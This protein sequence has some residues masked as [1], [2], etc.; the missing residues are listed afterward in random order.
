M[1][2]PALV[3]IGHFVIAWTSVLFLPKKTFI[4]YSSSAIL[5]SLLVLILSILAVPLNLWRVKGGIKTKIFN[6]LSFIFGPFFIGTLWIFR[7]TYK[8]FSLYML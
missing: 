6:D 4:R 3:R 5:A 8:N 7:M 1:L 2:S